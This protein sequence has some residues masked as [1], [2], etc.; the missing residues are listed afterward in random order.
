MK[1]TRK[2]TFLKKFIFLSLFV[3]F[4]VLLLSFFIF[5]NYTSFQKNEKITSLLQNLAILDSKMDR[6]FENKFTLNNYDEEVSQAKEFEEGLNA[7]K[8][9]N[10]N[11]SSIEEIFRAKI[12]QIEKFKSA[13]S[14]AI[15]SKTYLYELENSLVAS[16]NEDNFSNPNAYKI[17]S[18]TNQIL[19][20]LATQNILESST[21]SQ[22]EKLLKNIELESEK[23]DENL[24]LF[25]K[26]LKTA[27]NQIEIMQKNSSLYTN[28]ALSLELK[29]FSSQ[30]KAE[31]ASS[32]LYELYIAVIIAALTLILLILFI[33][34]ILKK[35]IIPISTLE[36]LSA[37]LAS[38]EANLQARLEIDSKS[39]LGA[40][41]TYINSFIE[42]V[43]NSVL[44][45][46]ENAKESHKFS[47]QLKNN[48][49]LLQTSSSEQNEEIKSV[50]NITQDLDEHISLSGNL[51]NETIENMQ[52]THTL[53][54][55]VET[56]LNGLTELMIANNEKEQGVIDNMENLTQT[57][58]N[59]LGITNSIK[60]IA[61]QTNLL[62]LNAAIE[63]ARAGEHGRGFAVVADEVRILADKT[64][65]SLATIN[66]TV[67]TIVQQIN[68]NK[69]LMDLIGESMKDTQAKVNDLQKDLVDSMYKLQSSIQ[70]TQNMKEKSI[71]VKEKM[72]NLEGNIQKVSALANS[73]KKLSKEVNDISENVLNGASK[74]SS[75]LST[76][77]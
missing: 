15:N 54:N 8:K 77:V 70:S 27:L 53:M 47:Q 58:D 63:A 30:I 1:Q 60:D 73:V 44:E 46:S 75:K 50:K 28:N 16:Y 31:F 4:F 9:L 42:I 49:H 76:F 5:N 6:I 57:A 25:I 40:S 26:H 67:Q 59:I 72:L 37:N 11:V 29:K 12:E 24:N 74:L 33:V 3:L 14:I 19:T 61:E 32:S 48:A 65:K 68:D 13:N 43:Q 17:M 56:T 36:R 20:I 41:A 22:I 7:L 21:L 62:A 69:S 55:K 51:A 2:S 64:G 34:L 52:H 35:V 10:V 71:E 38:A 18:N 45:A 66:A 23:N 39:E